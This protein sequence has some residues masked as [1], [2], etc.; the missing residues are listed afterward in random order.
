MTK[1][2][3]FNKHFENGDGA[4]LTGAVDQSNGID[5]EWSERGLFN[6]RKIIVYYMTTPTDSDTAIEAG[7]WDTIDW[8]ERID[9]VVDAKENIIDIES[10]DPDDTP[11]IDHHD[12]VFYSGI[13]S[14]LQSAGDLAHYINNCDDAK[15]VIA[16]YVADTVYTFNVPEEDYEI[17]DADIKAHVGLLEISGLQKQFDIDE[18]VH[19]SR[20]FYAVMCGEV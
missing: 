17:S 11:E 2:E 7:G 1:R 5:L 15:N 18:L 6:G 4:E 9:R 14:K 12:I 19:L 8:A 16:F 3:F 20:Q 10:I 13:I